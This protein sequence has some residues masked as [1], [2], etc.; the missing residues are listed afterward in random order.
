M[1]RILFGKEQKEKALLDSEREHMLH[2]HPG[3]DESEHHIFQHPN[4]DPEEEIRKSQIANPNAVRTKKQKV[5]SYMKRLDQMILKP[6]LI[7]KYEKDVH[8][9]KK[10][11]MEL[12][13][14]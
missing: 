2:K 4:L 1:Q 12:F 7:Y 11:F 14:N 5:L 3:G 13:M 6:L 8:K 10:E 9:R